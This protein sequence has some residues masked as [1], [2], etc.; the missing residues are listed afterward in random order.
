MTIIS[1]NLRYLAYLYRKSQMQFYQ[2][3]C[4]EYIKPAV[5]SKLQPPLVPYGGYNA[6]LYR[7]FFSFVWKMKSRRTDK[8][9]FLK[10]PFL[11][12]ST[13]HGYIDLADRTNEYFQ[14]S[15]A[16][17]PAGFFGQIKQDER[18]H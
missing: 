10:R 4:N 15:G 18:L 14:K 5:F 16:N 11:G 2:A 17:I 9:G 8:K 6:Q 3:R 7:L 1:L 12:L 13:I